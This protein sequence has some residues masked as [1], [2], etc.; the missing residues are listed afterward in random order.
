[1]MYDCRSQCLQN[2]SGCP[3]CSVAYSF[4]RE[5]LCRLQKDTEDVLHGRVKDCFWSNATS[6]DSYISV[7]LIRGTESLEELNNEIQIIFFSNRRIGLIKREW[8]FRG[9]IYYHTWETL[10]VVE[11]EQNKFNVQHQIPITVY[12]ND[13]IV[14]FNLFVN[15]TIE[16]MHDED[17]SHMKENLW[18][19]DKQDKN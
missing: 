19:P 12:N 13:F 5:E 3:S 2:I 17:Y 11:P 1:M 18:N 4:I 6:S 7:R 16:W 9:K 14:G 8:D 15:D 10:G